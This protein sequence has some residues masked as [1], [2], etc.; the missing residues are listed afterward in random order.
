MNRTPKRKVWKEKKIKLCKVLA[1]LTLLLQPNLIYED[2][3][4][5]KSRASEINF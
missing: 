4:D 1:V 2:K 5:N 3:N